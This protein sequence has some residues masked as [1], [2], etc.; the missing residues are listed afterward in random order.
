MR[1]GA[2]GHTERVREA[3]MISVRGYTC[4]CTKYYFFD[5]FFFQA[6]DGIRYLTVTGVQTCALPISDVISE[7]GR[8]GVAR[9]V[10]LSLVLA[11]DLLA[12]PLPD[13]VDDWVEG[14]PG[15]A[16]L[17]ALAR[18]RVFATERRPVESAE[19]FRFYAKARERWRDKARCAF[20][21]VATPTIPAVQAAALPA[22]LQPLYYVVRP[23]RL[24]AKWGVK[25]ATLQRRP[26]SAT[27]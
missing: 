26:P 20:H 18:Q 5:F 2:I 13:A 23:L 22:G 12:A 1:C 7:S 25:L 17:A 15:L 4:I 24:V 19:R 14:D 8:L 6:E 16:E 9:V 10:R 11:R 3:W 27:T 21:T